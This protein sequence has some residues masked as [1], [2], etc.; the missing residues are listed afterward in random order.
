MDLARPF[1]RERLPAEIDVV[2][3]L[4]QAS[5]G[6]AEVPDYRAVNTAAT[7]LLLEYACTA[8]ATQFIFASSGDVYGWHRG[9]AAEI[10]PVA[11][12]SEYALSKHAAELLVA[13]SSHLGGCVLRLFHPYGPGQSGRLIPK[14]AERIR[15]GMPV[16]VTGTGGP[17][18]SPTYIDDVV[19]IIDRAIAVGHVG[20]VNV[21]GDAQ[22]SLRE[23]ASEIGSLVGRAPSFAVVAS[24]RGD[25]AGDNRLMKD[26]FGDGPMVPLTDGLARTFRG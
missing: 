22:V 23:L 5:A 8:G 11:P 19:R 26:V 3:H 14:L 15:S 18:A 16:E 9:P 24:A 2:V 13:E 17:R 4:A 20:V 25:M 7:R 6:A 21:A 12:A 10:D 1:D